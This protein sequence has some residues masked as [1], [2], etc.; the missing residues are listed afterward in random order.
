MTLALETHGLYK[1]FGALTA[2]QA[3]NFQLGVGARH[4]IIG[5]NGSG[6]T[7]FI[8]LLTGR[9]SPCA[10]SITMLGEDVTHLSESER[11]KRG[12][13][14]TFQITSLLD[15]L[16]VLDNIA[17]G[18]ANRLG[19]AQQ[20]WRPANEYPH[21]IEESLRV[22]NILGIVD[23]AH[24]RVDQ[25][26]YGKQRLVEIAMSL[27]LQP[28]ILLLDEPAA[29]VAANEVQLI[30]NA[31]KALPRDIAILMIDHDMELIFQFATRITVLVQGSILCQGTPNE[32][33]QDHRVRQVY[34]GTE[35]D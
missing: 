20:M 16:S 3:V 27:G 4:A 15:H 26:P 2:V 30:L 1:R 7:S 29:G 21:V 28:K 8:N 34:L 23:I 33:A 14:R 31:L 24:R 19:I 6:K 22:L 10:G 35:D 12:L 32:I 9:Y 11:V 17:L 5:P 25:L 13:G 18:V